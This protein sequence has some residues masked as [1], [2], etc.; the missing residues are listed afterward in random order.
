MGVAH[1][2]VPRGAA[3]AREEATWVVC[4]LLP[5]CLSPT[6]DIVETF[7]KE[8]SLTAVLHT[9]GC[10]FLSLRFLVKL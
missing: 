8:C 6:K 2:Q 7:G 1:R 4:P 5:H 9:F 10:L 3:Q